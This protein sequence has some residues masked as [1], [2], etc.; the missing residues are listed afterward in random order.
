MKNENYITIL[1]WMINDL[2][3]SGNELIC[4]A[5][6]YGFSQDGSCEYTGS[7]NYVAE[8]LNVNKENARRILTRLV[9][10]GLVIKTDKLING[11]KFCSYAVANVRNDGGGIETMP[12]SSLGGIKT[13]TPPSKEGDGGI[14]TMPG[15][16]I[17]TMPNIYSNDIYNNNINI[18]SSEIKKNR[19]PK[20]S[21]LSKRKEEFYKSLVPFVEIYGKEVIR[22]FYDYWSEENRSHTKMRCEL[23]KTW[24]L[25]R[26]IAYWAS[27]E[28]V[29]AKPSE[30]QQKSGYDIGTGNWMSKELKDMTPEERKAYW[31]ERERE[32]DEAWERSRKQQ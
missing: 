1:G 15:G 25:E 30:Q 17:E 11:V 8:T 4:Y 19:S 27:R 12:V 23:E 16:G 18:E 9:S 5:M 10:K 31:K 28:R 13:T 21:L 6:I 20:G 22:K 7:L 3:L 32:S 2:R 24:D 29:E 14:E 26:R